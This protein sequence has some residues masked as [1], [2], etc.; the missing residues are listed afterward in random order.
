[1]TVGKARI[2][3]REETSTARLQQRKQPAIP[4][5]RLC[6]HVS[7]ATVSRDG[8]NRYECNNRGTIGSGVLCWVRAEAISE[9]PKPIRGSLF[10]ITT[11]I[12]LTVSREEKAFPITIQTY[13]I[14]SIRTLDKGEAHS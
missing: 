12:G 4:K 8:R 5:Q 13:A 6:R 9:E 10:Q 3:K 1:M 7:A 2:V 11:F 14:S